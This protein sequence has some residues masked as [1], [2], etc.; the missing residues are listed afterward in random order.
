MVTG[1]F[2]L[3]AHD[4]ARRCHQL[5]AEAEALAR[6][7]IDPQVAASYRRIALRWT[8]LAAEAEAEANAE[9]SLAA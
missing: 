7:L 4:R 3:N 2:D 9:E 1:L 5:A 6:S 8:R